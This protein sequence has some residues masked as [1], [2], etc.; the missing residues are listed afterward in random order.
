[1]DTPYVRI[2]AGVLARNIDR[3]AAATRE[4]GLALRPHAKTHKIPRIAQMQL[5][6]GAV[7]L[8]VATIG[9]AEVFVAHGATDVFTAYPL[10]LT[11]DR[12]ARL[13]RL[14]RSARV[15][16]GVDSV[17]GAAH[18]ARTLGAAAPRLEVLVEVDSGH[19]RSGA[20]PEDAASVAEAARA[21]GLR[22][23]G[24]FT[25]PG[26]SYAPGA[27][28]QAAIQEREALRTA[29]A[30]LEAAGFTV[31]RRS[32]GST[33]SVLATA[34][35]GATE[36]R[37]GVYVFGDAQ[38]LALGRCDPDDIAL[39]HRRR[40][41]RQPARRSGWRDAPRPRRG[42]QGA[43]QRPARLGPGLRAHRG[44]ARGGH[45]GAVGAPRDGV[46]ARR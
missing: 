7:G 36:V 12:A 40:D 14:A 5:D 25:F 38:Q 16:F 15:S 20:A 3:M 42:Q 44:A 22:V 35:D 10:W 30:G 45:R 37:P 31:E 39:A 8:T 27:P 18:A 11:P 2:D 6:A 33:P 9:E 29:A 28:E 26:H 23:A 21:G 41:R 1:M 34:A 4:R 46:M 24:V 43:R 13:E 17:E 19:H 32:G